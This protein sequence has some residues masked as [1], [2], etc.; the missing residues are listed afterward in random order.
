[1]VLFQQGG[2]RLGERIQTSLVEPSFTRCRI[3]AFV[4]KADVL[5][6]RDSSLDFS[7]G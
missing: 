6:A 4:S 3:T 7:P 2:H 1:M 5:I